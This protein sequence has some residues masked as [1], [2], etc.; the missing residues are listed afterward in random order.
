[1]LE[2]YYT[3][4]YNIMD[5]RYILD[6]ASITKTLDSHKEQT[7]SS[8]NEFICEIN[9]GSFVNDLYVRNNVNPNYIKVI[10]N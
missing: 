4:S 6:L 1:M 9:T 3:F 7:L 10:L 8:L 2:K 5:K